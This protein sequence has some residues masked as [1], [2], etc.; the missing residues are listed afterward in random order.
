MKQ[1]V[2]EF[3]FLLIA[4]CVETT[5]DKTESLDVYDMSPAHSGNV[6]IYRLQPAI[7]LSAVNLRLSVSYQP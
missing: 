6:V 2:K 4:Y 7:S 5:S 1:D 3:S